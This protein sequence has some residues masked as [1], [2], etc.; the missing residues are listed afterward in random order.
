M[1]IIDVVGA[2]LEN[3]L[4]PKKPTGSHLAIPF[5]LSKQKEKVKKKK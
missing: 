2:L 4:I 1:L 3:F 5:G